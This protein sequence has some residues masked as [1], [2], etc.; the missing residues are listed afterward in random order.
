MS[1]VIRISNAVLNWIL[2][3]F[4]LFLHFYASL[5]PKVC[6][7]VSLF[8]GN[9]FFSSPYSRVLVIM[10]GKVFSKNLSTVFASQI[11]YLFQHFLSFIFFPMFFFFFAEDVVSHL[12]ISSARVE[13]GG[14]YTCIARNI[15]GSI[16]HSALLNI[17]GNG[18]INVVLSRLMS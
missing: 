4:L 11:R 10:I 18:Y 17:H 12:N 6:N 2:E 7:F 16:Q 9:A 13:H 1:L 15:L 8:Q 5:W 3:T 14:L